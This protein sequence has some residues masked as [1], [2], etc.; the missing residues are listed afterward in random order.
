MGPDLDPGAS[1]ESAGDDFV[2]KHS[3][4]AGLETAT[5]EESKDRV[6]GKD[7]DDLLPREDTDR[8]IT[9][10]QTGHSTCACKD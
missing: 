2:L 4:K 3:Q 6:A 7:A 9:A 1:L 8:E 10:R 5:V